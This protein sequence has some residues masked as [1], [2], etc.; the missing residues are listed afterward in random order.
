ML[1][2]KCH[3]KRL[4]DKDLVP[5]CFELEDE[6]DILR[7]WRR[8]GD[9]DLDRFGTLYPS[10][11]LHRD[12]TDRTA[13]LGLESVDE[14]IVLRDVGVDDL[15]ALLRGFRSDIYPAER[16][17]PRFFDI[18]TVDIQPQCHTISAHH[19]AVIDEGL[20]LRHQS[21]CCNQ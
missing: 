2:D 13:F 5:V 18:V 16:I 19:T 12:R 15:D 21:R 17:E 14:S 6:V 11:D 3:I 9:G 8:V 10:I 1:E 4:P 20:H 7:L